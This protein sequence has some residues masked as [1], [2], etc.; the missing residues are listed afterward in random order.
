V[1]TK[2]LNAVAAKHGAV[3]KETP[4][5]EQTDPIPDLGNAQP[6]LSKI[7][8]LAMDQFGTAIEVQNGWAVPQVIDI[9]AA[10]PASFDEARARVLTDSRSERTRQMAT[11]TTTR[12]QEQV[13]AGGAS[14][15]A[16]AR[17]AGVPVKTSEK[18]VR[19]AT[20]PEFGSISE[21]D[22]EI[23]SLEPGKV[24]T[25]ATLG[26]KTLV[27]AVKERDAV[28]P[29][30]VKAALAD[31]R[32]DI[33]PSKRERYFMAYIKEIEQKMRDSRQ[34]LVN[35]TAMNQIADRVQ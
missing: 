21:R 30:D 5:A 28:K 1:N 15:E 20:I 25:P 23:F 26:F 35:E 14:L 32:K 12:I 2:D 18:L 7:F 13:K 6:Y 4:L 11:D 33:L 9:V 29:E 17:L 27:F 16:L 34:I 24:G 8:G 19:G 3:V 31:L 22:Q 10:H